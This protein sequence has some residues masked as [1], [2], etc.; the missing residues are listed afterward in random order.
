LDPDKEVISVE[1]GAAWWLRGVLWTGLHADGD[2][3]GE[4]M[5]DEIDGKDTAVIGRD[6]GGGLTLAGRKDGAGVNERGRGGRTNECGDGAIIEGCG[7]GREAAGS[8]WEE[9]TI[10]SEREEGEGISGSQG[11]ERGGT[12]GA[13]RSLTKCTEVGERREASTSAVSLKFRLQGRDRSEG[14]DEEWEGD[15]D[16]DVAALTWRL[17]TINKFFV[18]ASKTD[19]EAIP[20]GILENDSNFLPFNVLPLMNIAFPVLELT[21]A[22][23]DDRE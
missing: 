6:G 10:R 4:R 19:G 11:A 3:L 1:E 23:C 18:V 12:R 21:T 13:G 22:L 9:G 2:I 5:E 7:G 16:F 14:R 8:D 15:C 17:L 20:P